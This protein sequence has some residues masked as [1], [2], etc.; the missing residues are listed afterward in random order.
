M[1]NR[2]LVPSVVPGGMTLLSTT[3]L[4][5]ATTTLSSIPQTYEYLFLEIDGVTGNT[6]DNAINI[7]PNNVNNL[8]NFTRVRSASTPNVTGTNNTKM[9]IDGATTI[10]RTSADN[11]FAVTIYNYNSTTRFKTFQSNAFFLGGGGG[12]TPFTNFTFGTFRSNTAITSLVF[13][14]GGTD[15]FAGGTVRLYGVK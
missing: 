10:D 15:T 9:P 11:S 6:N 1:G 14:F 7:L 4:S 2:F 13:D 8:T 12:S 5:G 3:T